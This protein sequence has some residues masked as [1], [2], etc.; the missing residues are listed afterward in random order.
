[1]GA[2]AEGAVEDV[3]G[4]VVDC[5]IVLLDDA[6]LLGLIR[7]VLSFTRGFN[8]LFL[9]AGLFNGAANRSVAL[10]GS[11]ILANFFGRLSSSLDDPPSSASLFTIVPS[12]VRSPNTAL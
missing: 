5:A 11:K 3:E 6:E 2:G 7:A 9:V 4:A 12:S 10:I 8:F 1:M